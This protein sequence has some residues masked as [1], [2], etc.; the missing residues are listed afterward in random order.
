[1]PRK[2]ATGSFK[3]SKCERVFSMKAHLARHE[4]T[5][6]ASP[7]A[8]AAA[9]RL[10]VKMGKKKPGRKPGPKTGRKPGRPSGL[11]ARV[12]LRDMTLEQLTELISAARAEAQMKI[13]E[14]Q[15]AFS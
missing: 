8:R 3:C 7:G 5:I 11:A 1:M 4:S 2:R 9:K 13:A 12:G 14:Y 15:Q 10:K 6:H